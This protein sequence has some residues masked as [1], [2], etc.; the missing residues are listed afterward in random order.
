MLIGLREIE[1]QAVSLLVAQRKADVSLSHRTCLGDGIARTIRS[2]FHRI[3]EAIEGGGAHGRENFL[4][5]AKIPVRR[6]GAAAEIFGERAHR[7][8]FDA[9]FG[10]APLGGLAKTGAKRCDFGRG[11]I[12]RHR[13]FQAVSKFGARQALDIFEEARP[14]SRQARPRVA[15]SVY[16]VNLHRKYVKPFRTSP[17]LR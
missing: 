3:G 6:H 9:V 2:L 16:I 7:Y 1:H 10:K 15:K 12:F 4:L 14:L 17:G 5:V 11:E 13:S 8:A